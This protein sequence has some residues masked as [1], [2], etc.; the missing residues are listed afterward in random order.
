MAS[1]FH[2]LMQA[3]TGV[4]ARQETNHREEV[5]EVLRRERAADAVA[6]AIDNRRLE[7]IDAVKMAGS[8]PHRLD[9][10][11]GPRAQEGQEA[12]SFAQV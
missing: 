5:E 4:R 8:M 1:E 10:Q 7:A 9:V 3:S 11:G 12:V 6:S 2:I